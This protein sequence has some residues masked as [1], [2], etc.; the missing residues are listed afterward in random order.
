MLN[1]A[2]SIVGLNSSSNT[3]EVPKIQNEV[4]SE[5]LRLETP[6]QKKAKIGDTVVLPCL[7][8]KKISPS[9]N[10]SEGEALM[11]RKL[12]SSPYLESQ[13]DTKLFRDVSGFTYKRDKTRENTDQSTTYY[14]RCRNRKCNGRFLKIIHGDVVVSERISNLHA[15]WCTP[16]PFGI[17]I[18]VQKFRKEVFNRVKT[19]SISIGKAYKETFDKKAKELGEAPVGGEPA[20]GINR[21]ALFMNKVP[22]AL[23]MSSTASRIRN[24]DYPP[25]PSDAHEFVRNLP[26][27]LQNF[28]FGGVKYGFFYKFLVSETDPTCCICIFGDLG[29][30]FDDA[31]KGL[32][33]QALRLFV[34]GTFSI[35]PAPFAQL[36]TIGYI[37]SGRMFPAIYALMTNKKTETYRLFFEYLLFMLTAN[38]T[39]RPQL[40]HIMADFEEAIRKGVGLACQG[41]ALMKQHPIQMEGCWFHY[42]QALKDNARKHGIYKCAAENIYSSKYTNMIKLLSKL[43]FLKVADVESAFLQI[44]N[45][46]SAA[47]DASE[48]L[49]N[50]IEYFRNEWMSDISKWNLFEASEHKTNNHMEGWHRGL[51]GAVC[52]RTRNI[53]LFVETLADDCKAKKLEYI[54]FIREGKPIRRAPS[55]A[56]LEESRSR[57]LKLMHYKNGV[58]APLDLLLSLAKLE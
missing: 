35:V 20:D 12:G 15:D 42:V 45:R 2:L 30:L 6:L 40:T 32:L 29:G 28:F 52:N 31:G 3:S 16:D 50:Y 58:L 48:N 39:V 41:N 19:S 13:K 25:Q 7:T 54:Q 56:E 34:D 24:E 55:K 8:P 26:E 37:V 22:T 53:W 4:N 1:F 57:D 5:P 11:V 17:E 18:D 10:S 33:Q 38:A 27:K 46:Y 36:F 9:E 49:R 23:S 21:T 51:K 44:L 43:P 47:I 14:Y